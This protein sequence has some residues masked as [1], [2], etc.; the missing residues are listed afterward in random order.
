MITWELIVAISV[1]YVIMFATPG[2]NNSILTASGIKFG[3][4][5][6]IPNI[7]G[8]PSGHAIQLTLVCLGLGGLFAQ[9]PILLNILKYAGAAYLLYLAWKMLGSL[10]VSNTEDKGAP[11]KYYEAILF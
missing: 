11:L 3:F 1:Y 9:F 2:P 7:L 4:V 10:K 8:V 5:R 6:T